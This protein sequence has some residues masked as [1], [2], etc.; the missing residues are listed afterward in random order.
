[1]RLLSEAGMLYGEL[2]KLKASEADDCHEEQTEIDLINQGHLDGKN[3]GCFR[4]FRS[5]RI[6]HPYNVHVTYQR[7]DLDKSMK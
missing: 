4:A 6:Y 3:L 7:E 1:M 5:R 2:A